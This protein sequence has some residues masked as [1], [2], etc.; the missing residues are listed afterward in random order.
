MFTRTNGWMG[1]TLTKPRVGFQLNNKPFN[2][3]SLSENRL[4][5][6]VIDKKCIDMKV[7]EFNLHPTKKDRKKQRHVRV[8]RVNTLRPRQNGR[9]FADDIFNVF[10]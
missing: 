4:L 9:H 10:S 5:H 7:V 6:K 8:F 1:I 3:I 2:L